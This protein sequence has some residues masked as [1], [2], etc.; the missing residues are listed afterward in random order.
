MGNTTC[1]A[2]SNLLTELENSHVLEYC[3]IYILRN[4]PIDEQLQQ[5]LNKYKG[6]ILYV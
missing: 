5:T 6:K 3:M 4:L 1:D 2:L